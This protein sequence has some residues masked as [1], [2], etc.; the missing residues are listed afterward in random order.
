MG[1]VLGMNVLPQELIEEIVSHTSPFD[2]FEKLS[3]VSINFW[4][5]AKFDNVW[6]RFLAHQVVSDRWMCYDSRKKIN[7]Y[8]LRAFPTKKDSYLFLLKK[9]LIIDY[10]AMVINLYLL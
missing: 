7:S 1:D 6:E 3:I 9:L 8:T 4:S 2:A 5:P 10:G